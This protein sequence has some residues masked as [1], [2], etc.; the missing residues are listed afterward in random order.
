VAFDDPALERAIDGL[1]AR[2]GARVERHDVL[3][4]GACEDCD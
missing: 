3:L 2:L 1:S 4:R